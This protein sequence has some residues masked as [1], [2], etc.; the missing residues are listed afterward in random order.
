MLSA[1]TSATAIEI[2]EA[3]TPRVVLRAHFHLAR[4]AGEVVTYN[5]MLLSR[6]CAFVL[7]L[8]ASPSFYRKAKVYHTFNLEAI[9]TAT[10]NA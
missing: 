10:F 9:N 7:M 3:A 6:A 5:R 8:I 4:R 2:A 1:T